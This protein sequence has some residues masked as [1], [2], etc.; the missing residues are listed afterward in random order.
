M[1]R[2]LPSPRRVAA[3]A[4]FRTVG[5]RFGRMALGMALVLAPAVAPAQAEVQKIMLLCG[6]T[7]QLCPWFRAGVEPPEG[8]VE[9][10]ASGQRN[11]IVV[12]L[13]AGTTLDDADRWAYARAVYNP[14]RM[15]LDRV[16]AGDIERLK[17]ESPGLAVTPQVDRTGPGGRIVKV[18]DLAEDQDGTAVAERV[19][20]FDD[21]DKDGN[22]FTVSLT[23][24]IQGEDRRGEAVALLDRLIESYR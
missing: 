15:A 5:L 12:L 17:A 13:P 11:E 22:A 7:Q 10:R 2:F 21:T 1:T 23:V 4:R 24:A 8:W 19:A 16:V 3:P 14:E 6:G 20:T 9:D 18:Y